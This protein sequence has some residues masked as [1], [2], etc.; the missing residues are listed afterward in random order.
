MYEYPAEENT[1]ILFSCSCVD[2]APHEAASSAD[3]HNADTHGMVDCTYSTFQIE[4]SKFEFSR[5]DIPVPQ[6]THGPYKY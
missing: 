6:T 3:R 5:H 1:V 2:R 4:I